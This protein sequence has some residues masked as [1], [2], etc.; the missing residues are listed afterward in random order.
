M[1]K[2]KI[3][4][5]RMRCVRCKE[6]DVKKSEIFCGKCRK[7]FSALK[8]ADDELDRLCEEVIAKSE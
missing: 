6:V 4:Y 7:T 3:R 1:K 8:R 5:G 2:R